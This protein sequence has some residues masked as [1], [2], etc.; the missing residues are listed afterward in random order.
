MNIKKRIHKNDRNWNR[1]AL[2]K[3]REKLN[4]PN[5]C[6]ADT[7][8]AVCWALHVPYAH[9]K[10][11][12][13]QL[14]RQFVGLPL[15]DPTKPRVR[16]PQPKRVPRLV[17]RSQQ[18]PKQQIYNRPQKR[19]DIDPNGPDFLSSFAW[20]SLRMVV[21]KKF[22]ARCACCGATPADGIRVNVDHIKPRRK[23]PELALVE[24]NLQVLCSA[25]NHGKGNW[26]ETDWRE[27]VDVMRAALEND[28]DI[29][30]GPIWTR[31]S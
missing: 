21:L 6:R 7:A 30:L 4:M 13:Y 26:D 14:M 20:R 24:S 31:E 5:A 1:Q 16:R 25:C 19:D 3:A 8:Q 29:P 22:G 2:T 23:Y 10:F 9:H 12:Q 18:E 11:D 17:S 28:H 27:P 15:Q